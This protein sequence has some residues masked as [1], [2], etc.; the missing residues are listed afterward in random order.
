M[1]YPSFDP[2][3]TITDQINSAQAAAQS[4]FDAVRYA[5]WYAGAAAGNAAYEAI[6]SSDSA[7]A[8]IDDKVY[9]PWDFGNDMAETL[10]EGGN[11]LLQ[12]TTDAIAYERDEALRL[13]KD[14]L[15]KVLLGVGGTV[16]AFYLISKVVK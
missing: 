2:Y 9:T 8:W 11:E 3:A 7:L 15:W 10:L 5:P 12:K 6:P 13:A 14:E 4:G 1:D 16:L